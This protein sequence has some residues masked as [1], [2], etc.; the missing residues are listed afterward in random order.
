MGKKRNN[1]SPQFK[2]KVAVEALKNEQTAAQLSAKYGVHPTMI[3]SWKKALLDGASDV[4]AKGKKSSQQGE[5][6][7]KAFTRKSGGSRWNGIFC[8]ESSTRERR[9]PETGC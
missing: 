2:A 1:Y 5:G 8:L 6:M 9:L 7:L 3:S 4:F